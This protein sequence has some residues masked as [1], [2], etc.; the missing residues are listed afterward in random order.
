MTG[1]PLGR[2]TPILKT[3]KQIYTEAILLFYQR[4]NFTFWIED[5]DRTLSVYCN[6][7]YP[8]KAAIKSLRYPSVF[9]SP[10]APSVTVPL[11][12]AEQ[13][14]SFMSIVTPRTLFQV[15]V[16][17]AGECVVWTNDP[18][19]LEHVW[20]RVLGSLQGRNAVGITACS[21]WEIETNRNSEKWFELR[22]DGGLRSRECFMRAS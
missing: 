22:E 9:P 10:R 15:G 16:R 8:Y 12:L 4:T 11:T 7:P 21:C 17:A 19:A 3:N 6:L 20:A 5:L 13:E 1:Q 18:E 14:A 2:L